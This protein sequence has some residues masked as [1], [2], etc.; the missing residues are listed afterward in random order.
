MIKT[1]IIIPTYNDVEG[2]PIVLDKLLEFADKTYEVIVV[3][4]GSKDRTSMVVIQYPF[5]LVEHKENQGKGK[6][7]RTGVHYS[8]GEN[9]IW[10]DADDTYPVELIP[11][12]VKSLEKHDIVIC[13]RVYGREN[14]PRFNRIGNRLFTVMIQR[15]YGFKGRDV[16]SGLCGIKREHLER[17]GLISQRF[18]IEPEICMKSARMGLRL[19]EIPIE[20]RR[21]I[22]GSNLNSIK[23]GFEDLFMILRLVFW[24]PQRRSNWKGIL[25]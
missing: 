5:K 24:R 15:I 4:D 8:S 1:S 3:N 22:G 17:M 21:R 10:A 9:I 19:L 2:L 18:A 6:A 11:Q 16:C 12:M 7:L 25:A 23:V 14:V 13:P 20:Y